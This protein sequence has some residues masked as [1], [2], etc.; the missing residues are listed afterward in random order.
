MPTDSTAT[1]RTTE[2]AETTT[3]PFEAAVSQV[4]TRLR[5]ALA[6]VVAAIPGEVARGADLHRALGIGR[7]LS[8]RVFKVANAADPIATGAHVPSRAHMTSF[9]KAASK[10]GVPQ[11]VIEAASRA[12]GDFEDVVAK[13]AGDRPTFDSMVSA[14]GGGENAEQI[15]LAHRRLAFR[16]QR[17]IFGMQARTQLKLAAIQPAADPFLADIARIEGLVGLRQLRG[18]APLVISRA[19]ILNDDGSPRDTCRE[20]LDPASSPHRISLLREFCSKPLPEYR[21]VDAGPGVQDIE[22]ISRGVGKRAAITCIEGH[23]FRAVPRYR[24]NLNRECAIA[25]RIVTPCEVA[26]LDVLVHEDMYETVAPETRVYSQRLGPAP[27]VECMQ[28]RDLLSLHESA[29]YLGKG[30]PVLHTPDVPHYPQ[31]GQH[32]FDRLGWNG[33]VFDVYR[34]RIEYPVVPSEVRV[35]FGYPEA[36][37][38]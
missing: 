11:A 17:H 2:L 29:T 3:L 16:G 5:W 12:A 28:E 21:E 9:L 37:G 15:D 13:H 18:D 33:D 7:N 31:L 24:D 30:P 19:G 10:R 26:V 36:P 25:M 27:V 14:L 8:W 32:V 38:S 34:C 22:L 20:A 6:E 4:L 23:V 35:H 1:R